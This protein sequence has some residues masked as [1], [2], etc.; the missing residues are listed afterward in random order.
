[1]SL[2]TASVLQITIPPCVSLVVSG[3]DVRSKGRWERVQEIRDTRG[4]GGGGSTSDSGNFLDAG[5]ETKGVGGLRS[6]LRGGWRK[7]EEEELGNL[8]EYE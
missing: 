4:G 3:F 7:Y 8:D 1:M 6:I 2:H 5:V